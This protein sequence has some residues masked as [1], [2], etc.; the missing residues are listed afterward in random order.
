M[1]VLERGD[2]R[3]RRSTGPPQLDLDLPR[4]PAV[5]E[6]GAAHP[7]DLDARR[8]P[9]RAAPR[10]AKTASSSAG[11]T[12]RAS[13]WQVCTSWNS[14]RANSR[15]ERA[16]EPGERRHEHRPAAEL[17]GEADRVHRPGA[18]VGDQRE[19][20]RVA[21][22]LGR[23]GAERAG[24][25]RVR[26]RVDAGG[27]LDGVE[28][29]RLRDALERRSAS[30]REMV[31]CAVGD[32]P[33]RHVAEEDVRVGDRRLLA[34]AAVAGR[35][36]R[37]ARG[38]RPDLQAAARDRARRASRRPRR[39][40]RCR[41]SG[42]AAARPSRACSRL[43]ADSEPPTSYSRPRETAP[44]SISDAFAV[45]P[46]MSKAIAFAYPS[47]RAIPSAATTPAAGPDSRASTGR[48]VASVG[49]HHAAGR[50]HDRQRRRDAGSVEPAADARRRSAHQRPHVRVDDRRRGALVLALLAQD[51]ARERDG[52]ARQLLAQDRAEP[53]LVLRRPVGVEQA[54]R[55]RLDAGVAQAPGDRARLV[56][57]D[58]RAATLP[59]A[60]TRSAS[61]S[62]SRRGTSG[63]GLRQNGSYIC[64]MR[65]RRSS[66]TSRKPAVVTS[67]V[68]APRRSSTAFVATVVPWTT[69]SIRRARTRGRR[70]P[71]RPRVVVRRRREQ[72]PDRRRAVGELEDHVGEGA[73][74][75]DADPRAVVRGRHPRYGL[76]YEI[77]KGACGPYTGAGDPVEVTHRVLRQ[78]AARPL[79]V[80]VDRV[81]PLM[82]R[83]LRKRSASDRATGLVPGRLPGSSSSRAGPATSEVR[84]MACSS[85]ASRTQSHLAKENVLALMP[86]PSIGGTRKPERSDSPA[87]ASRREG[88]GHHGDARRLDHGEV[89]GGVGATASSS[90]AVGAAGVA[91]TTGARCRVSGAA[92]DPT[93]SA[94][95]AVPAQL[96]AR[97][98]RV[99]TSRPA[100]RPPAAG[101]CRP[102]QAKT[103]ASDGTMAAAWLRAVSRPGH[104]EELG[105][106]GGCGQLPRATGV[107]AAQQ[108]LDEPVH[109]LV[110]Q[111]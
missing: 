3:A 37:G 58:R 41:S 17:L 88:E 34:A 66:S 26:D 72:L 55:D 107:H 91:R 36:G 73:A 31:I 22:L 96:R 59:S 102:G 43:P 53:L 25:A 60:A 97:G 94:R 33:G 13:R 98:G 68:S 16:E 32:R 35:P 49:G 69:P 11:S 1:L 50:L 64:G 39:P 19:L 85:P 89:G 10:A 18:A 101:P 108:R 87:T 30:S 110:A 7:L 93:V 104:G 23:D 38:A 105:H 80:R 70:P 9:A 24:H 48:A 74:D 103:G 65:S 8:A 14:G 78:S 75:V 63:S 15:P 90:L 57:V 62:R 28:A 84:R 106:G 83:R 42:S 77:A 76:R 111:P 20:A 109:D 46:P 2:Q 51:L 4:L 82:I 86:R 27:S 47:R 54:D 44:L 100:A 52:D 29:E 6:L 40:R 21:A 67:A 99:R 81:R 56:R 92:A 5:A 12:A 61:S 79:H 71:R 45:V 95:H